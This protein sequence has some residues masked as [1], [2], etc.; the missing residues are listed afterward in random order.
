MTKPTSLLP[1]P[2]SVLFSLNRTRATLSQLALAGLVVFFCDPNAAC[3]Q[4][5]LFGRRPDATA[6]TNV[7][8]NVKR[9]G[10]RLTG[11]GI[12]FSIQ[13]P[14]NKFIEVQLF[15][16]K[17]RGLT[18]QF[19]G[20]Q[21]LDAREIPFEASG[22]GEYWFC[23]KTLDRNRQLQPNG[24]PNVE[25][26]VVVDTIMPEVD[27]RV[28]TDPAGRIVCRWKADDQNIDPT[29]VKLSYR[30]LLS[31]NDAENVWVDVPYKAVEAARN[32]TFT[33]Q[34]AFWG[35]A[36]SRE[37]VV[38]LKIADLGGNEVVLERQIM[39]PRMS[40]N[41]IAPAAAANRAP[42]KQASYNV[43]RPVLP[44]PDMPLPTT[45]PASNATPRNVAPA[46]PGIS[47]PNCPDG[48]CPPKKQNL[49]GNWNLWK[50]DEA[51][52]PPP[53]SLPASAF[54]PP[55]SPPMTNG[56][57]AQA[58]SSTS[59]KT[60]AQLPSAQLP[61][62]NPRVPTSQ[63]AFQSSPRSQELVPTHPTEQPGTNPRPN[64]LGPITSNLHQATTP[65][66]IYG[67]QTGSSP[68][69]TDIVTGNPAASG[70]SGGGVAWPS[71][72]LATDGHTTNQGTA[73]PFNL[74]DSPRMSIGLGSTASLP[75]GSPSSIPEVASVANA[76]V[77]T[78]AAAVQPLLPPSSATDAPARNAPINE[79][80]P[81]NAIPA[82]TPLI[83]PEQPEAAGANSGSSSV[84]SPA[85]SAPLPI[86]PP[87]RLPTDNMLSVNSQRF[88]LNYENSYIDPNL[89]KSV[90]L[91]LT[92]DGGQSW[93]SYGEDADLVSP[94]PVQVER[95]GTYGFRIVY[96]TTDGV[97]GR[98]P[99]RGDQPDMWVRVDVTPPTVQLISA[100]YGRGAD[101][102]S[103]VI[104]WRAE[105]FDIG[106]RPVTILWGQTAEGPWTNIVTGH[107]NTGTYS[108]RVDN[109]TPDKVFLRL[110]VTDAAG[111]QTVSQT[112]RPLEL[113]GLAPRGRILS[114]EPVK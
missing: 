90:I 71:R 62:G 75:S 108:W 23:L 56:A 17:N 43:Q 64:P 89:V 15:M 35:D 31:A 38:R 100:P 112:T 65:S 87:P 8:A 81:L 16:S 27:F 11:F 82:S 97:M 44:P 9:V 72:S 29:T 73:L 105:D 26:I 66:A 85:P 46:T 86:A 7:P 50:K 42:T 80:A 28:Q 95:E 32:G 4:L 21:N 58:A 47:D 20:R 78:N 104:N 13:D 114:V 93:T 10:T 84:L 52:A 6:A 68:A 34:Y 1:A 94:F 24:N 54:A 12:P 92:T 14:E 3:G 74:S 76:P 2:I 51:P 22:D 111:N 113:N 107:P 37:L 45:A 101:A 106:A 79:A 41:Q 59:N 110:E 57:V 102:G 69:P 103:L 109:Q 36:S 91:W 25:L 18:W 39:T 19:Y 70:S 61:S 40:L 77:G 48:K 55:S 96:E 30:S 49:L 63:A 33:D 67:G 53:S 99:A 5:N 98:T 88:R 83:Q 60:A